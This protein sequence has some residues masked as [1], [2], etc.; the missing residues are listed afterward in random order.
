[1]SDH[2]SSI[3][4][5]TLL[6]GSASGCSWVMAPVLASAPS[7]VALVMVWLV[8]HKTEAMYRRYTIASEA[9]LQVAGERL[10]ALF[11]SVFTSS[12]NQA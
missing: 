4:P 2:L 10:G 11:T 3:L 5:V 6:A 7:A 12:A 9:D 1:M 8:G